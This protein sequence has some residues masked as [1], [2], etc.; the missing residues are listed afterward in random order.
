MVGLHTTTGPVLTNFFMMRHAKMSSYSVFSNQERPSVDV[1]LINMPFGPVDKP[2]IGLGLLQS[3]IKKIG[4]SSTILN[5]TLLFGQKIGKEIYETIAVDRYSITEQ[6]G[7]WIFSCGLSPSQNPMEYFES[8]ILP[9]LPHSKEG[10]EHEDRILQLHDVSR[11]YLWVREQVIPFL[12]ECIDIILKYQPKIVGFTSTFQQQNASLALAK[13]I[14]QKLPQVSIVF[15]GGNTEGP[16][17]IEMIRQF[18]FIDA[19]CSGEGD[20]A[21]PEVVTRIMRE[22]SIND[23]RGIYTRHNIDFIDLNGAVPN[24]QSVQE[25]DTLSYPDYQDYFSQK[26]ELGQDFMSYILFETSRGCWWGAKSHCV[27][28]GL[29]KSTMGFR[30]K[31]PDR[32]FTELID[33]T[34]QYPDNEV[35]AVDNILDMKYFTTFL[36]ALAKE[37]LN[38]NLFYEVKANLKKDHIQLLRRAN[39]L[40]IQPGIESFSTK[41]LNIMHKGIKGIQNIQLLKWCKEFGIHVAWNIICGFPGEPSEEY[42]RMAEISLLITHFTPPASCGPVRLDRFSPMFTDRTNITNVRPYPCY[43]YTYPDLSPESHANLAYYFQFDYIDSRNVASYTLSLMQAVDTWTS[44]HRQS[45]LHL[46]RDK[47]DTW[48]FDFRP[49]ALNNI[50]RLTGIEE[51]IYV[52]C[53]IIQSLDSLMKMVRSSFDTPPPEIVHAIL[54]SFVDMKLMVEEDG[55]YLSLAVWLHD[56]APQLFQYRQTRDVLSL[57][58]QTPD[59]LQL[60]E[61][62]HQHE[63]T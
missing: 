17:G 14:K 7:E 12:N 47:E 42:T 44:T 2:S 40:K 18:P 35:A 49:I 15:G 41:V 51:F 20:I 29:N 24:T 39:I 45:T 4:V 62:E 16:M 59:F 36:P 56:D 37:N 63:S 43:D 30:S 11:K 33:L 50:F 52:T 31:S 55:L 23:I 38:I 10:Y 5:F 61:I 34:V 22:R 32:A 60:C 19:V 48:I 54:Q 25:M 3:E 27:F 58:N 26:T 1:L 9:L 28:C 57:L 53:D 6:I 13:R 8:I 46:M 21:F